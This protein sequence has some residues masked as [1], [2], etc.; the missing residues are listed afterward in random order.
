MVS[1]GVNELLDVNYRRVVSLAAWVWCNSGLLGAGIGR[2]DSGVVELVL[3]SGLNCGSSRS[4]SV[5]V[6]LWA[7]SV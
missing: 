3:G 1:G 4:V 5:L 6:V 2:N 7:L